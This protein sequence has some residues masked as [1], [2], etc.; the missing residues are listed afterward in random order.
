MPKRH[1][2]TRS[3]LDITMIGIILLSMI[4]YSISTIS[5]LSEKTVQLLELMEVGFV[6]IFTIEYAARIYLAKQKLKYIFSFYGLVDLI[7][8]LPFYLGLFFDS[9]FIKSLRLLRIFRIFKLLHYSRTLRNFE[10]TF[11]NYKKEFLVF[12]ILSV[13]IFYM[14]AVGIYQFEHA[15]QPEAF[16]SVF[17][18]MWWAVATLT[19]VGYGDVYPV[20]TGGKIFTA[21]ILI[22]GL[23]II[24]IP[25]GIIAA[26]FTE[27]S[28]D[29]ATKDDLIHVRLK[30]LKQLL[31][32][33]LIT[34]ADYEEQK[35][36]ILAKLHQD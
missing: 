20:T 36:R 11:R 22:I 27:L 19:T 34:Q 13:I 28:L 17:D 23:G 32:D 30:T 1:A 26:S 24:A 21:A 35:Q 16:S 8:I 4:V 33:D 31:N 6:L 2:Q 7:S 9:H 14:A 29:K 15:V 12:S 3:Y 5:N 10:L 25:A 18:A